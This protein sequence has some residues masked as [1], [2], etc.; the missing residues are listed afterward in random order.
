MTSRQ[1]DK[2]ISNAASTGINI[3]SGSYDISKD[4]MMKFRKSILKGN[5]K[6]PRKTT[7]RLKRASNPRKR[8]SPKRRASQLATKRLI[9]SAYPKNLKTS[10]TNVH[11]GKR[12]RENENR[13]GYI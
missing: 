11:A 8:S 7:S 2:F 1:D 9:L 4:L 3:I 12:S 13:P 5:S 10:Q 6:N